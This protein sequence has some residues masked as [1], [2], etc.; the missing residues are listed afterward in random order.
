MCKK[1]KDFIIKN[2]IWFEFIDRYFFNI[3]KVYH[4]KIICVKLNRNQFKN[5]RI[6]KKIFYLINK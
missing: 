5:K 2:H 6:R 1:Y 3:M 4:C